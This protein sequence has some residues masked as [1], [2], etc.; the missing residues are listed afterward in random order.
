MIASWK[1]FFAA[2]ERMRECQEIYAR[3]GGPRALRL[4]KEYE[5]EVDACIKAKHDEWSRRL[6]PELTG[7]MR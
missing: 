2:V 7:G 1:A 3:E 4:S 6:Q 5:A